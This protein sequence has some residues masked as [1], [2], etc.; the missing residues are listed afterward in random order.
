[1]LAQDDV[2]GIKEGKVLTAK[3]VGFIVDT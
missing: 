3:E 1:V 2:E